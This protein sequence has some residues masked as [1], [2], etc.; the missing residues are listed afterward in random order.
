MLEISCCVKFGGYDNLSVLVVP[1]FT[2]GC[3]P[4]NKDN[5]RGCFTLPHPLLLCFGTFAEFSLPLGAVL[6]QI[7]RNCYFQACA[8]W[9]KIPKMMPNVVGQIWK[10]TQMCS[11][12]HRPVPMCVWLG[13]STKS[14]Q[15]S[16]KQGVKLAGCDY[17]NPLPF[18]LHNVLVSSSPL[19]L[20]C[21]YTPGLSPTSPLSAPAQ[22][23]QSRL[24]RWNSR[25]NSAPHR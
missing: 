11:I 21:N 22:Y 6:R 12:L 7:S 16:K 4:N 25:W 13:K 24:I 15:L 8:G 3:W 14:R 2:E 20:P 17:H 23:S 19:P 1:Q 10:Q 5:G 18:W 9:T